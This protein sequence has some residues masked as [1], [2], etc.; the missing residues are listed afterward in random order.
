MAEQKLGNVRKE[1]LALCFIIQEALA[2]IIQAG[3]EGQA[4]RF[5]DEAFEGLLSGGG[6]GF[7]EMVDHN[8]KWI[9]HGEHPFAKTCSN[10][11]EV[12]SCQAQM[13]KEARVKM[14]LHDLVVEGSKAVAI[15]TEEVHAKNGHLLYVDMQLVL[16]YSHETG[17]IAHVDQ[18]IDSLQL[19][20]VLQEAA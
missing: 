13:H 10:L 3:Q 14:V 9:I 2:R 18:Y 15:L 6:K 5:F 17:K 4:R 1:V 19:Q 16:E 20:H 8:V 12:R 7:W 11:A